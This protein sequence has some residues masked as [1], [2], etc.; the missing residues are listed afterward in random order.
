MNKQE[1]QRQITRQ[2]LRDTEQTNAW[3]VQQHI[4]A[5]RLSDTGTTLIQ[6]EARAR[7]L[8]EH[9][10]ALLT[11]PQLRHIDNFLRRMNRRRTRQRMRDGAG[12]SIFRIHTQLKRRLHRKAA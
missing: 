4:Q 6:A 7:E 10:K 11:D 12:N 9:Y 2:Q 1:Q 5:D 3:L 8:I